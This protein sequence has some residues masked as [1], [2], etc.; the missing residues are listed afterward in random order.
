MWIIGYVKNFNMPNFLKLKNFALKQEFFQYENFILCK[1]WIFAI[2]KFARKH[3]F[4]C[5][6]NF[7][8]KQEFLQYEKLSQKKNSNFKLQNL[9]SW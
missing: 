4:F 9:Q 3:D 5:Y 8:Q 1:S 7:T 2:W 6:E